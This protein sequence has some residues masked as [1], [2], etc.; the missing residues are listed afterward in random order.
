M[1][2]DGRRL[3]IAA[4]CDDLKPTEASL[5]LAAEEA[6]ALSLLRSFAVV[7]PLYASCKLAETEASALKPGAAQPVKSEF[8]WLLLQV[9][10]EVT[11]SAALCLPT[12]Q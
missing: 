7:L 11:S 3:A 5:M 4:K 8:S 9:S 12:M 10:H 2:Y 1:L 6:A